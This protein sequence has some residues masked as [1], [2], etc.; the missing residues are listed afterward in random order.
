MKEKTVKR[1]FDMEIDEVSLV[2][3]PAN[4]HAAIAISKADEEEAVMVFDEQGNAVDESVLEHGDV[5]YNEAGEEFVFVEE[6]DSIGKASLPM[7]AQR[8]ILNAAEGASSLGRKG[9]KAAGGTRS[10][11]RNRYVQPG[12]EVSS[13]SFNGRTGSTTTDYTPDKLRRGLVARDAGIATAGVGGV[14]AAGY[15][16]KRYRDGREEASKSLGDTLLEELSKAATEDER[17]ELLAEALDEVEVA[18]AAAA[19]AWS[20]A[21]AERD[22][23]MTEEFIA[24]AAEYNV[25]VAPG[26]LGPILKSMAETLSDE[27]LEVIDALLTS[28][29]DMLYD[30]IGF[31]GENDNASVLDQVNAHAAE[32]VGKADASAAQAIAD[33]F[34]ANPQ[35]YD[36]YLAEGR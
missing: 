5:V 8:G 30:E 3:R 24:K 15:G 6:D 34:D 10:R 17:S 32:L 31:T 27:Q 12:G 33:I 14:G 29:G 4:Q 20:V 19:E 25:P 26:V 7:F 22:L 9:R 2:D 11:L 23:R 16:V 28:V 13:V 18:K 21:E 35:A 1:L 36:A